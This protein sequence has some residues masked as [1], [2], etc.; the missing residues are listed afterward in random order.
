[1]SLK[2]GW[3]DLA[4]ATWPQ[5][6][7]KELELQKHDG[8]GYVLGK[9]SSEGKTT[10]ELLRNL[11]KINQREIIFSLKEENF[12][13]NSI[14]AQLPTGIAAPPQ[15]TESPLTQRQTKIRNTLIKIAN[16]IKLTDLPILKFYFGV[17]ESQEINSVIELFRWLQTSGK[18]TPEKGLI[19]LKECFKLNGRDD[20]V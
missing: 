13:V 4:T 2:E 3:R 12:D 5:I 17:P 9:Y 19:E 7:E 16:Q 6:K 20:L 1:L 18:I 14:L 11:E 15:Q 10:S 8:A